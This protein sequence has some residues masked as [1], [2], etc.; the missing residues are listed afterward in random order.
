MPFGKKIKR[1]VCARI[2]LD[3]LPGTFLFF[4]VAGGRCFGPVLRE[5]SFVLAKGRPLV[6]PGC[7]CILSWTEVILWY[8]WGGSVFIVCVFGVL[9][10]VYDVSV[11]PMEWSSCALSV[12]LDF[13]WA[14]GGTVA[15][16][17][18]YVQPKRARFSCYSSMRIPSDVCFL[19][20]G[21]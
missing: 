18:T 5:S 7:V 16:G 4:V 14:C 10:V 19:L 12:R 9:H 21:R 13:D 6:C 3:E 1:S 2:R 20:Y 11:F 17:C 15:F 8:L